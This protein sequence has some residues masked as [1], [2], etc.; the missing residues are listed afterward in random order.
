MQPGRHHVRVSFKYVLPKDA[1]A[2]DVDVDV[3]L[4]QTVKIRYRAPMLV[5]M[6]GKLTVGP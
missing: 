3:V 5:F 4:G 1:G 6:K 2:N